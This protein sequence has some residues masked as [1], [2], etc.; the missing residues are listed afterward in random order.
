M[1]AQLDYLL[2]QA[3]ATVTANHG[4]LEPGDLDPQLERARDPRHGDFTSNVAMRLAQRL[5]GKPRDLANHIV[6]ALPSSPLVGSTEVAGAGFIN[7][8]LV[9][10]AYHEELRKILDD[11]PAYGCSDFGAGQRVIVEYV[12][13]NPTG[14]LHVGH[15][16]HAAYGA[17][18]A[19]LLRACGHE[20]HEEYYVND[21]GRQMEILAASVWLRY[22]QHLGH[23]LPFPANCYQGGYVTEIAEGLLREHSQELD[24]D[25]AD[26]R[27]LFANPVADPEKQLDLTI[28]EIKSI[29]GER[30]FRLAFDAALDSVLADI[31][32]D[33]E[34]FGV[35][36]QN[37]YSERS[38]VDSG[39]I[40]RT[41]EIL[42]ANGMLYMR[43]GATWFR[44][45]DFGD[46]KDRVVVRENG[47]TTY[48]A[49]DIAYHFEKRERG[50]TQ[51]LDVLGADHH[52]YV[53]RVRAGL[54]A[55]GAPP[56]SLE[57]RLVQ[58]VTLYR[59]NQKMQMSTRSGEYVTLRQ[60]REEVGND[61]ARYFYVSRSNDQ[62]LD[63][64]LELAKSQSNDNPV[65]YIQ[66]AHA[67]VASMLK[68]MSDEN[69]AFGGIAAADLTRLGEPEEHALMVALS[70]F[71]EQVG[72]AALNR[73]PQQIAHFLRDTA[74]AFH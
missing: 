53:A 1:R 50:F 69:L 43:D 25:L 42:R 16:R 64:D 55:M 54:E 23:E 17:S 44:A 21:A 3:L 48:F 32:N 59:G 14:P 20:V 37:W 22:A 61:A 8:R 41:L 47:V 49:S 7:F 58:F 29:L 72:L 36:P 30:G 45:T 33:L 66:Y 13:A 24:G 71:P 67:R 4:P 46:E 68:R 19:S 62:H 26:L 74:A 63:F 70:R 12:S 51:L 57:V 60:L 28:A 38:L 34:E 31:K 5:G 40:T 18:L 9:P 56:E 10:A 2:R 11:G 27:K 73:A 39:A 65:Y 52:G 15:G 6:A 35:L